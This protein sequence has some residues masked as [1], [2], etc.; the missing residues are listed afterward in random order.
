MGV[1]AAY[2]G[3]QSEVTRGVDV[4]S[5]LDEALLNRRRLSMPGPDFNPLSLNFRSLRL[6]GAGG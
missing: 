6:Y 5:V 1:R 2:T 3:Y 4:R